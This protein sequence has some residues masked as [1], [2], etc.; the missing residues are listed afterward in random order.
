MTNLNFTH[1]S[2]I[3]TPFIQLSAQH[4]YLS[5][6]FVNMKCVTWLQDFE[7]T[8]EASPAGGSQQFTA[9]DTST[10]KE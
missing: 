8:I 9:V 10:R 7:N 6:S 4:A 3:K 1:A 2:P 5:H